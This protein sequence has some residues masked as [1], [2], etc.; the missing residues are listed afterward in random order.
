MTTI[1]LSCD[2][3][4]KTERGPA[5]AAGITDLD[6]TIC[7][8]NVCAIEPVGREDRGQLDIMYSGELCGKCREKVSRFFDENDKASHRATIVKTGNKRE[9]S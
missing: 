1:E 7:G 8:V 5:L 4:G 6:A 9:W 2:W 3:C